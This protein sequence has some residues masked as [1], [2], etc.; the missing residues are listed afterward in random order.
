M[1]HQEC[2]S[3]ERVQGSSLLPVSVERKITLLAK[4]LN[5]F[6]VMQ[7]STFPV[8][9]HFEIDNRLIFKTIVYSAFSCKHN[10]S[11]VLK[12]IQDKELFP[13]VISKMLSGFHCFLQNNNCT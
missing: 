4:H 1:C 11:V 8:W 5:V 12:K 6:Q 10:S 7:S 13:T 3:V 9:S 2:P